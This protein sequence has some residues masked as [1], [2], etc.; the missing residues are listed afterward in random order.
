MG[1]KKEKELF[2]CWIN[3]EDKILSFHYERGY[4]RKEFEVKDE[5]RRF[6]LLMVSIGYKIQ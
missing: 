4:I 1:E 2:V 5:Y 6:I 3:D